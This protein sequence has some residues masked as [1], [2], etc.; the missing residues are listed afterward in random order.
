[1]IDQTNVKHVTEVPE[2]TS[3][4]ITGRFSRRYFIDEHGWL[5]VTVQYDNE[6]WS[7]LAPDA[8]PTGLR[9]RHFLPGHSPAPGDAPIRCLCGGDAFQI[10][11]TD[12]YETSGKCIACGTQRVVHSG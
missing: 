10:M 2:Y 4:S 6:E 5:Y 9:K 3:T 7:F 12:S 8:G 1:M 11:S